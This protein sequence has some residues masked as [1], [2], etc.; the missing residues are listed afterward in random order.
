[1]KINKGIILVMTGLLVLFAAL[2]GCAVNSQSKDTQENNIPKTMI[3]ESMY[4]ATSKDPGQ[5]LGKGVKDLLSDLPGSKE[6]IGTNAQGTSISG[7]EYSQKWFGL[8]G[9]IKT[10]YLI[11][12]DVKK[13]VFQITLNFPDGANREKVIAAMN[14]YLGTPEQG[15]SEKGAPSQYYAHWTRGGVVYD[16]QDYGD[17][18]EVYLTSS[19]VENNGS[20]KAA[21]MKL[22]GKKAVLIQKSLMDVDGDGKQEPIE[23]IGNKVDPEYGFY[24]HL[25]LIVGNAGGTPITSGMSADEDGGYDPEF[26]LADMT[27]DGKLDVMVK[28]ASGGSSGIIYFNVFTLNTDKGVKLVF[29]NTSAVDLFKFSGKFIDGYKAELK[30][31]EDNAV[32]DLKGRKASYDEVG[33]YKAG[34]LVVSKAESNAGSYDPWMDGISDIKIVSY[35]KE[36]ICKLKLHQAVSGMCNADDIAYVESTVSLKDETPKVIENK[37]NP[38]Q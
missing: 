35:A 2:S 17:Y 38:V 18:I 30:V 21:E 36:G 1:M 33:L 10:S 22:A 24:D 13:T 29:C 5:V 19:M 20:F 23:L 4:G 27:G 37:I 15:K 16:L 6:I 31:N 3:L 34:K 11:S 32:M 25:Y 7:Y 28:S 8:P 9:A 26:A 14:A 12:D